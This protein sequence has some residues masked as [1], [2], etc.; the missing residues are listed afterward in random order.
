M[1]FPLVHPVLA[2]AARGFEVPVDPEN[3]PRLKGV[4]LK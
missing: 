1:Y 3:Q 4:P 2:Y